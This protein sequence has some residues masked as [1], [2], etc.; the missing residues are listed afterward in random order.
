M[1]KDSKP[2][3]FWAL[4]ETIKLL[5]IGTNIT[6]L[7]RSK[8]IQLLIDSQL[9]SYISLKERDSL[10]IEAKTIK[11]RSKLSHSVNMPTTNTRFGIKLK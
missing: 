4:P 6:G 2:I 7:S 9:E 3:T 5:D 1:I 8:L 11:L 10:L